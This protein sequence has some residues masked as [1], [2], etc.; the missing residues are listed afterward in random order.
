MYKKGDAWC[1][2]RT[3]FSPLANKNLKIQRAR[4]GR[5]EGVSHEGGRI[6]FAAS[7]CAAPYDRASAS[8]H[9]HAQTC[10]TCVIIIR[11]MDRSDYRACRRRS[12]PLHSCL[13]ARNTRGSNSSC[14]VVPKIRSKGGLRASV[15]RVIFFFSFFF[16]MRLAAVLRR[17]KVPRGLCA[18]FCLVCVPCLARGA[19][20]FIGSS[21]MSVD[22]SV[23]FAGE[24]E[25]ARGRCGGVE[26]VSLSQFQFKQ[27]QIL[28]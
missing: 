14:V 2:T 10:A 28:C 17:A 22:M 15:V 5:G 4:S 11:R 8:A 24:V 20:T 9:M 12:Q 21:E 27:A 19:K 25:V 7:V 26:I 23:V 16:L 13:S 1:F 18:S 3:Q 6:V